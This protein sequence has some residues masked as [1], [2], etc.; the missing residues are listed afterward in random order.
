MEYSSYAQTQLNTVKDRISQAAQKADRNPGDI[1]LVG[2]S[3]KQ[4]VSL[5]RAFVAQGLRSLGENY[6][7]E[8]QDK[9]EALKDLDISWHFIGAI[10][11]NK[12]NI[13]AN[14]FDW[15]HSV[16]RLK[17]AQR[18]ALQRK[19]DVPLNIV[20]QL[21]LDKEDSKAGVTAEQLPTLLESVVSLEQLSCRGF[22]LIPAPRDNTDDQRSIYAKARS[23]MEQNNLRFGMHMDTLS[24]GMSHDL[25]AAI[26]EGSTM[27]RIGTDLFGARST[28]VASG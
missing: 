11:S 2:A 26:A 6:L 8:A 18:L 7:Q 12:T 9:Q 19:S 27:V 3:K 25:E 22:M 16:D 17:I 14:Q 24:M 15:V 10:Q 28:N 21:N 20:V 23:L 4:P 5:I 1:E 13:I